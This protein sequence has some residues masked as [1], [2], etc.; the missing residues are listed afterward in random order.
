MDNLA[1]RGNDAGWIL[2]LPDVAA[3]DD[4]PNSNP[5]CLLRHSKDI[6]KIRRLHSAQ[7]DITRGL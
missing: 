4:T 2:T 5:G 1:E 7:N 3:K 6:S